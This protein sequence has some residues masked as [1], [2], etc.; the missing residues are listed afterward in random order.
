MTVPSSGIGTKVNRVP[1]LPPFEDEPL[2]LKLLRPPQ[3][4]P[5]WAQ[6]DKRSHITD[7]S[8][9]MKDL[10]IID[11][12]PWSTEVRLSEQFQVQSQD[13]KLQQQQQQQEGQQ[14][15]EVFITNASRLQSFNSNQSLKR[16]TVE[17]VKS[18]TTGQP[19]NDKD[20][21]QYLTL[22]FDNA[23]VKDQLVEAAE[24]LDFTQMELRTSP[25][26][27]DDTQ[28]AGLERLDVRTS[29]FD[30]PF[31]AQ[32]AERFTQKLKL[33]GDD[34]L[35]V[36][37]SS[38]QNA[39][40]TTSS[41]N[42]QVDDL[43]KDAELVVSSKFPNKKKKGAIDRTF[44]HLIDTNVKISNDVFKHYV[45]VMAKEFTFELDTFQKY[46]VMSLERGESVFVAAHTSAGKT[47]IAE[48][49]IALSQKHMT[50]TIY[51]SPIKALSNQKFRDFRNVFGDEEVGLV[52]GDVQIRPDA[53]CVI[54]TTE[55][56]RS[57][58]YRGAD[59][60]R[61][62]EFVVFDEVHYIND[63]E[64][65]VVWEEVIIM[66]PPHITIILLSATVPNTF[67]FADWVGRT[68]NKDIYVISTY[69]RPIPLEHHLF[70]SAITPHRLFRI[71]DGQK[72][73][74]Q[75]EFKKAHE[76][77]F[78]LKEEKLK[79]KKEADKK[80][81]KFTAV[82][83][84]NFSAPQKADRQ[85]WHH[86][87]SLLEKNNL[88][89]TVIFTFSKKRCEEYV[90]TL[91]NKKLLNQNEQNEVH[92]FIQRSIARLNQI[93]RD[94]PQILRMKEMLSRGVAVHHSGL[95]PIVK[96]LVE[97]LFQRNLI[98]V[99]FAT[100]TFAMGVNFPAKS[101]VFS[102][103]SKNDG[104]SY[105]DL[106]PGEY[107]QMS[108]RA[109]RRGLDDVGV[110][111]LAYSGD[112]DF[113]EANLLQTL[114]LGQPTKLESQFRLT[115]NM[116]LNLLRIEAIKIEDMMKKSF[117]EAHSQKNVPITEQLLK[118]QEEELERIQKEGAVV[119]GS[120]SVDITATQTVVGDLAKESGKSE[121]K[122]GC[123]ICMNDLEE[124]YQANAQIVRLQSDIMSA[125]AASTGLWSK[126]MPVGR[127]CI[128]KHVHYGNLLA[129][130]VGFKN[131]SGSS[132]N[133]INSIG[134]S[135]SIAAPS[136]STSQFKIVECIALCN[137]A[138]IEHYGK[139][140]EQIIVSI[141]DLS[142]PS[143]GDQQVIVR[144][145]VKHSD[146]LFILGKKINISSNVAAISKGDT[147]QSKQALFQLNDV[148][149]DIMDARSQN[150]VM[151]S[152]LDIES[153]IKD[154]DF[155]QNCVLRRSLL[156]SVMN[157]SCIHCP[158]FDE[159]YKVVHEVVQ[160]KDV[161]AQLRLQLSDKNLVMM[162]EYHQRL[163]VLKELGFIDQNSVV[164]LKGRVA[165]EINAGDSLVLTEMLMDNVFA[166][167]DG[168]EVVALL[169]AFVFQEKT[170]VPL[171]EIKARLTPRLNDALSDTQLIVQK[172]AVI[173][174][175][176]QLH[177]SVDEYMKQVL[178]I[179]LAEVVYEWASGT[180]F[181]KIIQLT[182]I[183]EGSIVRAITRLDE[184]CREM[185]DA[186]RTVGNTELYRVL[187]EGLAAIKRDIVFAAS[188]YCVGIPKA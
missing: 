72:N 80:A 78:A 83:A 140:K 37:Q 115:Y 179:G 112:Y 87:T 127:L 160:L 45:P 51:T 166:D 81:G 123:V 13:S 49:A 31:S 44:A 36:N 176:Y 170:Q 3:E 168:K 27:F 46:A 2:S 93:D 102:G 70:I 98:K 150:K 110:V 76:M 108:G 48:Y 138:Q 147:E 29:K 172:V 20:L 15:K 33:N 101:V 157:F 128:V 113:P 22:T 135:S 103:T 10:F 145:D 118:E 119:F 9:E 32:L 182:D 155:Q 95:L 163:N 43:V 54:M 143:A 149:Q 66:L 142:M 132:G 137:K 84:G 39:A 154:F 1:L 184:L 100:E 24:Q 180:P 178:N 85:L 91:H 55:I 47:V 159:H 122:S 188:L 107:T 62:V 73:F 97:I 7:I 12:I 116:I 65:G 177:V 60:I 173:Q 21:P 151:V 77:V 171:D 183:L 148:L 88:L 74:S 8:C 82:R 61:D 114:I 158:Q 99:L 133:S 109:G 16:R 153:K 125:L 144:L 23:S 30:G 4:I 111:I 164:K 89:P 117:Y 130:V 104:Q 120:Q 53:P 175:N 17:R 34:S 40:Y 106:L 185:R 86:L 152:E 174:R 186:A 126:A 156:D 11:D 26:N 59:L 71:V 134:V 131:D 42:Q 57:M 105:R 63:L 165:C 136:T 124:F 52:T 141:L 69:Q 146:I 67:E 90:D 181:I 75:L 18:T 35:N 161:M 50:R 41:D 5:E 139:E 92:V 169:S 56:L 19:L 129:A 162:P 38:L 96:E 94:L 25:L 79:K 14:L 167:M 121:E 58:L 187:D 6:S 68:K 64:R 28:V